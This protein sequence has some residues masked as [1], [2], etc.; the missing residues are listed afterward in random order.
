VDEKS[1]ILCTPEEFMYVNCDA[2]TD[3]ETVQHAENVPLPK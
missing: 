2:V 1:I 3:I